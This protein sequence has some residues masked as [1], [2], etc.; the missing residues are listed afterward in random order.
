MD[1][2]GFVPEAKRTHAWAARGEK[3]YGLQQACSRPRTSLIAAYS[4]HKLLA[5]MLF[6][7]TCNGKVFHHWLE[8]MLLP[9]LKPG[10]ETDGI[11]ES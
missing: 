2:T 5:P 6:S 9:Q 8:Q 1:E 4:N 10:D 7:G 3:V 11:V